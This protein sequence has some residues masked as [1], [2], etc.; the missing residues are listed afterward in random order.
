V[1]LKI[2]GN[3]G[4]KQGEGEGKARSKGRLLKERLKVGRSSGMKRLLWPFIGDGASYNTISVTRLRSEF[5][6]G[7]MRHSHN[8]VR[9]FKHPPFQTTGAILSGCFPTQRASRRSR[10][11]IVDSRSVA[12]DSNC[13]IVFPQARLSQVGVRALTELELQV[14]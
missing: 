8:K 10:H 11:P 6:R 12:L 7:Y 1:G 9:T 14:R 2:S 3:S 4:E 5:E 13:H